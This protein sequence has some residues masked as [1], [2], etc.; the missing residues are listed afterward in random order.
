MK[1]ASH[2]SI[3]VGSA[4]IPTHSVPT[5]FWIRGAESWFRVSSSEWFFL[6]GF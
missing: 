3:N 4:C 1:V 2:F 5:L 6:F